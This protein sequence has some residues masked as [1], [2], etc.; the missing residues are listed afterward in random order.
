MV[1]KLISS[2]SVIAKVL[3]DLN[4]KEESLRI[5]DMTEWCGEAIEKIGAITQLIHK[6]SGENGVPSLS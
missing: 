4:I 6:T 5:S 2:R 1:Y 3:A